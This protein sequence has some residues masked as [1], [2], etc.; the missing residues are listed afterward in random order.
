MGF[1]IRSAAIWLVRKAT[2]S[3]DDFLVAAEA[4]ERVDS[5][6]RFLPPGATMSR[7]LPLAF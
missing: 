1:F 5:S 4:A 6:L 7:R 3:L 2:Y